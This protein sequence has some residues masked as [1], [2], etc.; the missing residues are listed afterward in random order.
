MSFVNLPQ[1]WNVFNG[2]LI[3]FVTFWA[4]SKFKSIFSSNKLP[5]NGIHATVCCLHTFSIRYL[6]SI[7]LVHPLPFNIKYILYIYFFA[8]SLIFEQLFFWMS[9][10]ISLK[11]RHFIFKKLFK[12]IRGMNSKLFWRNKFEL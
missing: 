6:S 7:K 4:T 11:L 12:N 5:W 10:I 1:I 8:H 9:C 2:N 3:E